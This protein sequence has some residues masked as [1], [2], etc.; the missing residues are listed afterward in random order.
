MTCTFGIVASTPE[1]TVWACCACGFEVTVKGDGAERAAV[2]AVCGRPETV[3]VNAAQADVAGGPGTHLK[4]LLAAV[5]IVAG[6]RCK[7]GERAKL[8]DERGADWVDE[9]TE[10]VVSWLEEEARDRKIPLFSKLAARML[11][12]KA[13]RLARKS[14]VKTIGNEP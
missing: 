8:M 7:C 9:N 10:L 4:R 11:V 3:R 5:G 6:P 12:K 13:V 1:A 2:T 14:S